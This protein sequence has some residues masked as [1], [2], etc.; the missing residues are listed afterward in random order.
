MFRKIGRRL[1]LPHII[2]RGGFTF[3]RPGRRRLP[4][5]PRRQLMEALT[6]LGESRSIAASGLVAANDHVDIERVELDATTDAAGF[7]GC[8]ERR[9]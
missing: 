3:R 7:L 9:S 8:D 5:A 4:L 2:L 1:M 6:R